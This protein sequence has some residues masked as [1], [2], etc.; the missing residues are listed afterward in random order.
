MQRRS[1]FY[2]EYH[3]VVHSPQEVHHRPTLNSVVLSAINHL[4]KQLIQG[5]KKNRKSGTTPQVKNLLNDQADEALPILTSQ[6][7]G[8]RDALLCRHKSAHTNVQLH[9][10][11]ER[12]TH[13]Q[14]HTH[15][16]QQ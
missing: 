2:Q 3:T 6:A 14:T 5:E 16:H 9:G 13:T 12:D 4:P 15:I 10:K 8:F 1:L 7:K 11:R